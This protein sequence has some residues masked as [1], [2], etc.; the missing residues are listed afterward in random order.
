MLRKKKP[1]K[2]RAK[3]EM[4]RLLVSIL[5]LLPR[6]RPDE[7]TFARIARE[8]KVARP[9]LYYYFGS[10]RLSMLDEAI[11]YGMAAF[12]QLHS[13]GDCALYANWSEFETRRMERSIRVMMKYPWAADLYFRYRND[14]GKLGESIRHIEQQY[15]GQMSR[16]WQHF[17]EKPASIPAIRFAS[18]MK[19]GLFFGFANDREFWKTSG[20]LKN[21]KAYLAEFSR[22]GIRLSGIDA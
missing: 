20:A 9:T 6:Y 2:K 4:N 21:R 18:Y 14:P 12:V 8:C 16:A 1:V 13:I 11:R 15:F 22:F 5:Q 7:L 19:L 17:H 3:L 10:S